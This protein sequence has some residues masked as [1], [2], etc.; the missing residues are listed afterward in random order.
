MI[1]S[2]TS[3][4][5]KTKKLKKIP[6][7]MKPN[8]AWLMRETSKPNELAEEMKKT[9]DAR[10]FSI[11]AKFK[12]SISRFTTMKLKQGF[13]GSL[14]GNASMLDNVMLANQTRGSK[15]F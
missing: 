1:Q 12:D 15:G 6:N 8:A 2:G 7:Y 14:E 13:L 10:K 11:E 3:K 9:S 5:I 4:S